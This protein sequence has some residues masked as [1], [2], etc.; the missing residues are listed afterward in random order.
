MEPMQRADVVIAGAGVVGL[1]LA[2]RLR[3]ENMSVTVLE[4]RRAGAGA[5]RA[6]AGMLA[7]RDPKNPP[8]L[9]LLAAFSERWYA[10]YLDRIAEWSGERVPFETEWTLEAADGGERG[11]ALLPSLRPEAGRFHRIA[12]HSLDPRKL[13][14]GLLKAVRQAG[15]TVL[16]ETAVSAISHSSGGMAMQ[17][18][19]GDAVVCDRYVDCSGAWRD[20]EVRPV[21]GQ[22]LRVRLPEGAMRAGELGNV[23][24]RTPEVY[25]V[26]R[27]D[28][29]AL[30]GATVEDAGFCETVQADAIAGLR[31]QAARLLPAI[32]DAPE[33]ESWAGLRPR[34]K[35][36]LPMI[37]RTSEHGFAANG[38]FRNGILLAPAVAEIMTAMLRGEGVPVPLQAFDPLRFQVQPD[39]R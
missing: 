36:D 22:M 38:M 23:V 31:A 3:E 14:S 30:I 26:P 28:G 39:G 18:S 9:L 2:L 17:T 32:A 7:V 20:A 6:A 33:V 21:K 34:T 16:E 24:V 25:V 12:E 35:D 1:M 4:R 11:E 29:T 8:E 15:G 37:G 10:R 5:S 27:L 19:R 13:V